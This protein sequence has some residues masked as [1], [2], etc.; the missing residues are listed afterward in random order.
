MEAVEGSLFETSEIAANLLASTSILVDS[1]NTCNTANS[2]NTEGFVINQNGLM[3]LVG[4]AGLKDITNGFGSNLK[5]MVP[6]QHGDV[7][8]LFSGLDRHGE[9]HEEPVM[10]HAGLLKLFLGVYG[11]SSFQTQV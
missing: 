6:L 5:D 10:V 9:D 3:G 1:W 11:T 2:H 8:G 7:N 4:F